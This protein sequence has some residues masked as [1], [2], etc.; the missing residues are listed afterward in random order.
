MDPHLKLFIYLF[1]YLFCNRHPSMHLHSLTARPGCIV[2]ELDMCWY[3][4]GAAAA[5]SGGLCSLEQGPEDLNPAELL[6]LMGV[7]GLLMG[8]GNAVGI[9]VS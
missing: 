3:A 6:D 1:I 9:T 8:G 4:A 2:I 5:V 7:Q